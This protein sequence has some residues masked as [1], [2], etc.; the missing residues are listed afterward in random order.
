MAVSGN[1]TKMTMFYLKTQGGWS[2][3]KEHEHRHSG[4]VDHNHSHKYNLDKLSI[5]EK[6]NLLMLLDK[7]KDSSSNIIDAEV[8]NTNVTA[9]ILRKR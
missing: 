4:S 3:K 5:S 2:E 1:N 6:E 7:A 8:E 9:T